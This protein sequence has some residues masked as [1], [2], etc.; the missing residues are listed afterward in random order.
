M[1]SQE[2]IQE[3]KAAL[4]QHKF[5]K[6]AVASMTETFTSAI[7]QKDE[8]YQAEL[9]QAQNAEKELIKQQEEL[10]ASVKDLAAQLH[11]S[12]RQGSRPRRR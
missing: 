3:F 12:Y 5:D 11:G 2:I 1:E 6:E 10:Q 7:K 4:D 8:Q 9:E